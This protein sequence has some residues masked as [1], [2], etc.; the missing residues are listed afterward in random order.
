MPAWMKELDD[1]VIYGDQKSTYNLYHLG[2]PVDSLQEPMLVTLDLGQA[3]KF[4]G[5]KDCQQTSWIF[6]EVLGPIADI[7]L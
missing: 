6:S 5:A 7:N 3:A 4:A 2:R 1:I